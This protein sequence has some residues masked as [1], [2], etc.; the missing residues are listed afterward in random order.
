MIYEHL[1]RHLPYLNVYW[2]FCKKETE[3]Y[4]VMHFEFPENVLVQ[5]YISKSRSRVDRVKYVFF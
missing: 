1:L 5:P 3:K 2:S 4:E